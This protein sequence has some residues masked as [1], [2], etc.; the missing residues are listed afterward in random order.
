MQSAYVPIV[1]IVAAVRATG[2]ACEVPFVFRQ[3]APVSRSLSKILERALDREM[4]RPISGDLSEGLRAGF[5]SEWSDPREWRNMLAQ[6][7][8]M[9]VVAELQYSSWEPSFTP[10]VN[11][12]MSLLLLSKSPDLDTHEDPKFEAAR[13]LHLK[14]LEDYWSDITRDRTPGEVP[15]CGRLSPSLS[16]AKPST[17]IDDGRLSPL[18]ERD[19]EKSL[20]LV[21]CDFSMGRQVCFEKPANMCMARIMFVFLSMVVTSGAYI[22]CIYIWHQVGIFNSRLLRAYACVDSRVVAL[23]ILV[24]HWARARNIG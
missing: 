1:R 22:Y 6:L 24:K 13:R 16:H 17:D 2:D 7:V 19:A 9:D 3:S 10:L 18:S 12:S 5:R 11:Q 20:W 8:A 15:N 23:G 14:L 21:D 4:P